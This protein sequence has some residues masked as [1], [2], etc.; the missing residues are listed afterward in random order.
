M[1]SDAALSVAEKRVTMFGRI[2]S[3]PAEE[4]QLLKALYSH[5]FQPAILSRFLLDYRQ[6]PLAVCLSI[7]SEDEDSHV[8]SQRAGLGAVDRAVTYVEGHFQGSDLS[9]IASV[10]PHARVPGAGT[11]SRSGGHLTIASHEDVAV[12]LVA[13]NIVGLYAETT[14]QRSL[15]QANELLSGLLGQIVEGVGSDSTFN[16]D[17]VT[18]PET[19]HMFHSRGMLSDPELLARLRQSGL[20]DAVDWLQQ[21]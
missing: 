1:S 10:V 20:A 5:H 13:P 2:R 17:F 6:P 19:Q 7:L 9:Q 3:L 18:D 12:Q 14:P 4:A 15:S 16:L 21:V 8:A 11:F